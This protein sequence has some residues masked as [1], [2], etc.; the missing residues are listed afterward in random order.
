MCIIGFTYTVLFSLLF[1]MGMLYSTGIS[2]IF[3]QYFRIY[4]L[5]RLNFFLF[6]LA[7]FLVFFASF[8]GVLLMWKMQFL[9]FFIYSAATIL[10][11]LLELIISGFYLPDI[12]INGI[13]ILLFFI[14]FLYINSKKKALRNAAA[15]EHEKSNEAD[16]TN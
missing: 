15:Q 8:I 10:F 16:Q 12:I 1:L 2:G 3:D 6:A 14:I 4:D 9:G 7:G 5:S 13:F 11:L